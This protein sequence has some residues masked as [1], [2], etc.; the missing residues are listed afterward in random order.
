VEGT[1]HF[2]FVATGKS[3]DGE[4]VRREALRDKPVLRKD[5]IPPE[6]DCCEKLLVVMEE[7]TKALQQLL[8]PG[9]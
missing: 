6:D 5:R 8:K 2:R 9:S 4:P 1:Y 3:R 7:Q